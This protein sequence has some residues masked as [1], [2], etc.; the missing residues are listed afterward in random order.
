MTQ[1]IK[2]RLQTGTES[3]THQHRGTSAVKL[4]KGRKE[5]M[6]R[7]ENPGWHE[8]DRRKTKQKRNIQTKKQVLELYE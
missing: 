4:G 1:K 6:E 5:E 2:S 8:C 3:T 7:E